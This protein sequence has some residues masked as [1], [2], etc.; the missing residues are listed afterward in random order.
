MVK[1]LVN[2]G[3]SSHTDMGRPLSG[4]GNLDLDL[5]IIQYENHDIAIAMSPSCADPVLPWLGVFKC[6]YQSHC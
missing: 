4:I 2:G 5:S 1:F 6:F 3:T